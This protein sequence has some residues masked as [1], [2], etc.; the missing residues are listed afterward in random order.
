MNQG[1]IYIF[2]GD[3]KGKTSAALGIALRALSYSLK[4]AWIAWYKTNEKAVEQIK[5]DSFFMG[6]G[7]Y[8][9]TQK[10]TFLNNGE[11]I[12]DYFSKKEHQQ[13][14]QKAVEKSMQLLISQKYD[15]VIF[16]EICNAL[17]DKLIEIIK[18][19]TQR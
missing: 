15:V 11:E 10:H 12:T 8:L 13:A 3:G 17:D 19:K 7:F 18:G 9:K 1:L 5:I 16:D 4:V 2:S 14:A 6:K